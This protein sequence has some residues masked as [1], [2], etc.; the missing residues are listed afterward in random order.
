M[1]L[2]YL[3]IIVLSLIIIGLYFAINSIYTSYLI[4][5]DIESQSQEE[6][7]TMIIGVMISIAWNSSIFFIV[8]F[9]LYRKIKINNKKK[10]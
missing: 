8:A 9:L 10:H 5:T 7:L 6:L 4:H 1:K 2:K 3:Q